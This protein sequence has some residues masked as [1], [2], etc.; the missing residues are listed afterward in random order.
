VRTFLWIF[1]TG[2]G[3]YHN[4]APLTPKKKKKIRGH[5][6][7]VPEG[8]FRRLIPR[9]WHYLKYAHGCCR[10]E[11]KEVETR[12]KNQSNNTTEAEDSCHRGRK[13]GDPTATS[14]GEKKRG[15]PRREKLPSQ[16]KIAATRS[17]ETFK[18]GDPGNQRKKATAPKARRQLQ[19][20]KK[21]STRKKGPCKKRGR[22]KTT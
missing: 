13:S 12:G 22:R 9:S 20:G 5:L 14:P 10:G 2:G 18:Q 11:K 21:R 15:A 3:P 4:R 17:K 1:Q 7:P 8:G 19:G 6:S 16:K